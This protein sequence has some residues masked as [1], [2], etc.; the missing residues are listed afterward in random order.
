MK[1]GLWCCRN[2]HE[3]MASEHLDEAQCPQCGLICLRRGGCRCSE[4]GFEMEFKELPNGLQCP[5][6]SHV[7]PMFSE[8]VWKRMVAE[9]T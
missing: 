8:E 2:G 3:F 5:S 9:T 4:C 7:F 1:D 6:C